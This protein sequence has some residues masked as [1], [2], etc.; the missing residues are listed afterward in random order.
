MRFNTES[1]LL[2]NMKKIVFILIQYKQKLLNVIRQKSQYHNIKDH[3]PCEP[4]EDIVMLQKV[5]TEIIKICLTR[6]WWFSRILLKTQQ[7]IQNISNNLGE[8]YY[9]KRFAW[10]IFW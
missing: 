8:A 1:I 4:Y 5:E 7:C 3:T 10:L 9:K 2:E 6:Q